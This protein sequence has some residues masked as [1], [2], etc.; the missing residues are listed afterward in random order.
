MRFSI[1]LIL[2]A[3]A[4][5]A[6]A[7]STKINEEEKARLENQF[8]ALKT[9]YIN[10]D[11]LVVYRSQENEPETNT[12]IE[13]V[14]QDNYSNQVEPQP[15]PSQNIPVINRNVTEDTSARNDY[16]PSYSSPSTSGSRGVV[17]LSKRPVNPDMV[18]TESKVIRQEVPTT[19]YPEPV[20]NEEKK[21]LPKPAEIKATNET[22]AEQPEEKATAQPTKSSRKKSVFDKP[23]LK[24]KDME[25][26]AMAV[27]DLLE[28]LKKEQSQTSNSGS[29]SSRI[30]R[31]AGKSSLRKQTISDSDYLND[32]GVS[33]SNRGV[34]RVTQSMMDQLP[35]EEDGGEVIVP[36]PTYFINGQEVE[37][38]VVDG[39]RKKDIIRREI[40]TRNTISGN[41]AGEVWIEVREYAE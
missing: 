34:S 4:S 7:Q 21:E 12:T 19:V 1:T 29:M 17:S 6:F 41:P 38:S 31:G 15:A 40:R 28:K 20:I 18:I 30:A 26:A 2:L 11:G 27:D 25:E 24:Y 23:P 22:I 32:M 10:D 35:Y 36:I 13:T 39:L 16:Q 14:E 8:K 37:K 9:F 5:L 3:C 33:Q